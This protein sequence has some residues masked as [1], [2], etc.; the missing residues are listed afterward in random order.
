MKVVLYEENPEILKKVSQPVT[1]FDRKLIDLVNDMFRVT[2]TQ[3]GV[4]LA[5][6][7]L[8]IDKRVLVINNKEGFRGAFINPEMDDSISKGWEVDQEGCL[9][10]PGKYV[11][12]N[13]HTEVRVTYHNLQGKSATVDLSGRDARIF[14]H[15]FD[16]LNGI[17]CIDE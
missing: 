12:K 11:Q 3:R 8:G 9:S 6:I 17:M 15:E 1:K 2:E 7:Q 16:H 14:Q 5:A 10:A 13:R 4:G